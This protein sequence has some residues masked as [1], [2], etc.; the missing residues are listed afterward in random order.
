VLAGG[1]ALLEP[2][3]QF[4]LFSAL[5]AIRLRYAGQGVGVVVQTTGD[6]V[7]PAIVEALL[8]RS[9]RMISCAGMDDLRPPG[10]RARPRAAGQ[11]AP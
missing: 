7:T 1:E 9:V 8:A 5:K 2:V 4:V 11:A 10:R 3:R 6:L